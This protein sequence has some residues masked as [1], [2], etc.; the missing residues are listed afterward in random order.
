MTSTTTSV[1]TIPND[2]IEMLDDHFVE[3]SKFLRKVLDE[4]PDD[5]Q[6]IAKAL[7]IGHRKA[8]NLVQID[9]VFGP[10]GISAKR[11]RKIGWTKLAL[12]APHVT[13]AG[14]DQW[15]TLAE[16]MTAYQLKRCL[17][18]EE[19]VPETKA[20]LL[21]LTPTQ[22]VIFEKALISA[23]ATLSVHGFLGREAALIKILT[24]HVGA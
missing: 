2:F 17:R 16:T 5:F 9:R 21:Y 24:A 4:Q 14:A 18:G 12:L 13:E 22:Y 3:A 19:V 10:L 20:V 23:G 1:P 7:G 15:L 6:N 8:Y 11:L